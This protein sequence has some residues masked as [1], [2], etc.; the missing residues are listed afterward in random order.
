MVGGRRRRSHAP[1]RSRA[2]SLGRAA[3]GPAGI[4]GH[5]QRGVERAASYAHC[6]IREHRD[7]SA[8][9]SDYETPPAGFEAMINLG[10]IDNL[11]TIDN[12]SKR[13]S[14]ETTPTWRGAY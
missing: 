13:I 5:G 10:M 14:D 11:A 1:D 6:L 8:P 7:N 12:V 2:P 4:R 9:G 3:G